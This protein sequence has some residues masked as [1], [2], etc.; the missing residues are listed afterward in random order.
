MG[1]LCEILDL[2]TTPGRYLP[3][4]LNAWKKPLKEAR[5]TI[6][7]AFPDVYEVGMSHLGVQVL[8]HLLNQRDD[9][10]C[11]RAYAPWTDMEALMRERELPLC[12][13]EAEEPLK[14]FDLLGFSLTYELSYSNVLNM[15]ELAGVP[16]LAKERENGDWPLV[17]G[18]GPCAS[19]PEPMAPFFDAFLFGDGEE[20]LPEICDAI[21]AGKDHGDDHA[22]MLERLSKIEG[23]YVPSF[24][25]PQYDDDGRLV[26]IKALKPGYEGARRRI[27]ANLDSAY[28]PKKPLMPLIEPVHDRTVI[29]IARG[30]PQGCRFCHA[31]VIN[32]PLRERSLEGVL[33]LS[34]QSLAATGYE[35]C[36]MLSLSAG[37][38]SQVSDLLIS[39]IQ[40]HYHDR[41]SVSLPSLRVQGL[42]DPMLRAIESVRK[43]GFTLAPEAGSDRLRRVINKAYSEDE[44]IDTATRV[45]ANGWRNMKLYFMI[46]LPTETDE[47]VDEIVRLTRRV[48]SIK[49][50]NGRPRVSLSI[51]GF[52]PK[53]HT[54]FQW[55][56]QATLERFRELQERVRGNYGGRGQKLKWQAAAT[57]ILEGVISRGDRR[58]AQAILVAHQ[59]GA[60]FDGW[61]EHFSWSRW[62]EAFA[63]TGIDPAFYAHRAREQDEV[64]PWSRLDP[65]VTDEWLWEE[66]TRAQNE[67]STPDCR[68]AGCVDSCGV[69]DHDAIAPREAP[70][71]A[72]ARDSTSTRR[73]GQPETFFRYRVKYARR[74]GMRFMGQ[75][76]ATRLFTR[77]VRR[78]GLPMRFS[79]GHHPHPRIMFSPAPPVGVA[80]EAEY[81]DID[82]NKRLTADDL[83]NGLARVAPDDIEILETREIPMNSASISG[84]VTGHEY[85]VTAPPKAEPFSQE[86]IDEFLER[87]THVITQKRAKGD[88]ELDLRPLV[89]SLAINDQGQLCMNVKAP[90]GP[91]AKPQE[92]VAVVFGLTDETVKTY[93]IKRTDA[94]FREARPVRFPG[95][96]ERA[97]KTNG[98]RRG[99]G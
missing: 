45:F 85:T 87:E 29:E 36:S 28:F 77:A 8:Y 11:D 41:V 63:E 91:G 5:L 14:N 82:L 44:L 80:S 16:L 9:L 90:T 83:K 46:G 61:S 33:E 27:V 65:R 75:L 10:A 74:G 88:R 21:I 94:H 49:G 78:A 55:A 56:G 50:R 57:S 39:L 84:I 4:E 60:R 95:R 30:C 52:V 26:A 79:Q 67:Q 59:K 99:P 98:A 73:G 23:V 53:P 7:L 35:E 42:T 3:L 68:A 89:R 47:D 6:A 15:L 92:V 37:D 24:F 93:S 43:T 97:R 76:E 69:C 38:Y 25:E 32:R 18:G 51:S 1:I 62:E 71:P 58:L 22:A 66:W 20:A 17:I 70:A 12:S 96:S 81:V 64:F 19:N 2:V 48:S 72:T 13:H 34:R 54:P 86:A 40:E 31:G